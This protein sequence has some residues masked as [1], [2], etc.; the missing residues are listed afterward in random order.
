MSN[1]RPTICE[2]NNVHALLDGF[3]FYGSSYIITIIRTVE[4]SSRR[5]RTPAVVNI[6]YYNII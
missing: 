6:I 5:R 2:K 3:V 1:K 4:E